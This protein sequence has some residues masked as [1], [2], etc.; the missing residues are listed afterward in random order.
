VRIVDATSTF[1]AKES[2]MQRIQLLDHPTGPAY[3][4][5][6]N[7]GALSTTSVQLVERRAGVGAVDR[8]SA[9]TV[10]IPM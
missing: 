7:P 2:T 8:I 3:R 10:G 9:G 4:D 5:F 1:R 6:A